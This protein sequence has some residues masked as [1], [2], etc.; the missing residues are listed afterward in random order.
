MALSFIKR[1]F[2]VAQQTLSLRLIWMVAV[3]CFSFSPK[4]V[5]QNFK[6]GEKQTVSGGI[7]QKDTTSMD[8]VKIETKEE[9]KLREKMHRKKMDSLARYETRLQRAREQ[10][11]VDEFGN[12]IPRDP[13]FSDS[14]SLSKVCLT[15]A[16]LPGY[17]QIYNKQYWKLPIVYG[18]MGASIGMWAYFGS[19]YRPLKRQYEEM[20]LGGMRRTEEMNAVQSAMIRANTK[21][22]VFMLTTAASYIYFLG[23]AALNYSTNEVSSVK[24]ATTLSLICPGA[25]QIYN[26]SYWR[27]P[28]VW[29]GLASMIYVIDWNN[30]GFQ[31]FKKAYSLRA[32][33]EQH[34]ENYPNGSADEF[35]GRYSTTFLKNLRDSNRRNRDL[36]ILLTAGIY[37]FQAVDAHVDAHL[38]DFDISDNLTVDIKPMFDCQY[39]YHNGATPIFG[40]DLNVTF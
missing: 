39:T 22:Q 13:L 34:P 5:A 28:I 16:V 37:V 31:R 9:L 4:V 36:S 12:I 18:T 35:G 11:R 14:S 1:L 24:K 21:K 15:A 30:R 17:G 40:F 26:K 6:R 38:K 27:A 19:E 20:L 33:Y 2:G 8:S 32:D 7:L 3:L 23:D 25:G 29:G 10:D